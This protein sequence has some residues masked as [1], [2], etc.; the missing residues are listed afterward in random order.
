M[1]IYL[2]YNATCPLRETARNM[3]MDV[4]QD[5]GNPSSIHAHGRRARARVDAARQ[6]FSDLLSVLPSQIVFTSGG[7][8]S[9][10][11][12]LTGLATRYTP[13]VLATEHACVLDAAPSA[14]RLP[15]LPSGLID[16]EALEAALATPQDLPP[17][18]SVA[19]VNNET[20]VIQPIKD[21]AAR[22]HAK[23][24]VLHVD[25]VQALGKVDVSGAG[26]FVDLLTLSAHKCGGPQ[27]VGALVVKEGLELTPLIR[28]GGQE[29]GRRA[30]THN[31][32]GIAAFAVAARESQAELEAFLAKAAWRDA[33]E[34]AC[35][36][37]EPA[38]II[39]GQGAPRVATVSCLVHPRLKAE[40][41]VMSLD[42]KGVSVSA[43]AAC[44][45]G[46]VQKSHVLE[47]MGFDDAAAARAIRLSFGWKTDKNELDIFLKNWTQM[48]RSAI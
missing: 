30:G 13:R 27:G 2:D 32:A 15:V 48:G 34:A 4:L 43:G 23:G 8:E 44:S 37:A 9:N 33:L 6:G 36:A 45:S 41:Q 46:K 38:L 10:A 19:W 35:L 24:G 18:V 42:L 7:S 5:V 12:A 25:A 11:L 22:V 3:M 40:V 1:P 28:G 31:V 47:A 20:G 29:R 26:Q 17:L 14:P 16:M 21:I 39:A